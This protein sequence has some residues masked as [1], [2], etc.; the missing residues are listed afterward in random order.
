MKVNAEDMVAQLS[1][2]GYQALYRETI[3]EGVTYYKAF[4]AVGLGLEEAKD[5]ISR[6]RAKGFECILVAEGG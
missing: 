3:V 6:L 1:K 2:L 4:A 5:V